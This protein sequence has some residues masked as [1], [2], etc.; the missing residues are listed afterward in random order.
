[1]KKAFCLLLALALGLSCCT[2]SLADTDPDKTAGAIE[3]TYLGV[4]FDPPEVYRN[5]AGIVIVE[6][7]FEYSEIIDSFNCTYYAMSEERYAEYRSSRELTIPLDELWIDQLFSVFVMR[8]GM[9]FTR[10][11]T[12]SGNMFTSSEMESVREIGKIGDT[13]Y[14]LF[15]SGP[16]P[17]FV[18]DVDPAYLDEYIALSSAVDD[19]VAALS[20]SEAQATPDPYAGFVGSSIEFTTTDMDGNPVSSSDL[21]SENKIT[22]LNVWASWCGPCIGELEDLQGIHQRMRKKGVGV[23][24][25]LI[26]DDLDTARELLNEFNV[27]YPVILA[28]DALN[29]LFYLEGYPTTLFIGSDGTVLADSV[30]GA[31]MEKIMTTLNSLLR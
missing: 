28:P 18:A 5:T 13:T 6:Q 10:F 22:L 12:I 15:M 2:V 4:R 7:P 29:D 1:M 17:D 25:M 27:S 14:Y 23:I 26:D 8:N 9:T 24:G 3:Y 20:F 30:I 11:N 16:N 19:V 31:Y 21:F